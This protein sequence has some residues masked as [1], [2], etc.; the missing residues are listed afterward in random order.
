MEL[1][2]YHCPSFCTSFGRGCSSCRPEMRTFDELDE[3]QRTQRIQ[4]IG[5]LLD[6]LDELGYAI[7][8]APEGLRSVLSARSLEEPSTDLRSTMVLPRVSTYRHP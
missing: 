4:E 8:E 2:G 1:E 6:L 5:Q 7:S 3:D